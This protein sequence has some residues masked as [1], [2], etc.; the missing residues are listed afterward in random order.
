MKLGFEILIAA[1]MKISLFLD[2][3]T[4]YS[5]KYNYS[6]GTGLQI[7]ELLLIHTPKNQDFLPIFYINLPWNL[8]KIYVDLDHATES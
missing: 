7:Q 3:I 5:F 2:Y 8:K 6:V 1:Y 4:L